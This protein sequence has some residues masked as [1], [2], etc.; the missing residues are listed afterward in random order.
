MNLQL[1]TSTGISALQCP[2]PTRS[3]VAHRLRELCVYDRPW[4]R[5]IRT[6]AYHYRHIRTSIRVSG[7]SEAAV[8]WVSQYEHGMPL[9]G[10]MTYTRF[11]YCV[12]TRKDTLSATSRD[13]LRPFTSCSL[14]WGIQQHLFIRTI[15]KITPCWIFVQKSLGYQANTSNILR[16]Y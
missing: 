11:V 12:R 7:V 4:G 14:C 8:V 16:I 3:L 1:E 5:V 2:N 13:D 10:I 15:W 9:N 6:K